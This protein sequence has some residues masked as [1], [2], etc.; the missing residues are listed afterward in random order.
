MLITP[1]GAS[2]VSFLLSGCIRSVGV[3]AQR[4]PVLL[5]RWA[6]CHQRGLIGG[7]SYFA[8]QALDGLG[9]V[10]TRTEI[11]IRIGDVLF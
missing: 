7:V 11:V 2:G 10:P 5:E 4:H 8:V 6:D 1:F 9:I 3:V